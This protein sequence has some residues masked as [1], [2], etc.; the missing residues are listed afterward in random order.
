MLTRE[1]ICGGGAGQRTLELE[2]HCMERVRRWRC[3]TVTERV[4]CAMR[5]LVISWRVRDSSRMLAELILAS[6]KVKGSR[7]PGSVWSQSMPELWRA[8]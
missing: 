1:A 6:S 7:H 5:C 2:S 8:R 4:R 3:A